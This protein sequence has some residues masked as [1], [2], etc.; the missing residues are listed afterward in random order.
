[1]VKSISK[2]ESILASAL[3]SLFQDLPYSHCCFFFGEAEYPSDEE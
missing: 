2:L 3:I 1:M